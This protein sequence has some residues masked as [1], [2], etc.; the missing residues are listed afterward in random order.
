MKI[1]MLTTKCGPNPEENWKEGQVRNVCVDEARYW[2]EM[3]VCTLLEPYPAPEK[4]VVA[5]AQKA[6]VMPPETAGKGKTA[7]APV[8]APVA[9]PASPDAAA[10]AAPAWPG[11]QGEVK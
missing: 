10:Q 2:H 8:Q 4:A 7:S 1:K 9:P 3:G 6:V 11:T 5:P